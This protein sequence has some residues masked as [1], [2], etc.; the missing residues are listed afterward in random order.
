MSSTTH[1]VHRILELPVLD[2]ERE[3][4][5]SRAARA[6]DAAARE[7]LIVSGLRLVAMRARLLGFTGDAL[8]DAIQ[9]GTVGLIA[10]VD[11]FD[12]D[13]GVRLGTYAW[14][15]IGDAM[16]AAVP[17]VEPELPRD[18]AGT[19]TPAS[20]LDGIDVPEV[21]RLRYRIGE[22]PGPPRARH[23]VS[24]LLG[25][26]VHQVRVLETRAMHRLRRGLARVVHRAPGSGAD[27]L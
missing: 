14:W 6:G 11:R 4:E 27:P 1:Y 24:Q 10:A 20:A 8:G 25:I 12:P 18:L 21:L 19:T 3:V 22:L 16:R 17:V 5:L 26:S 23:E 7:Q 15:W 9:C 13:R 2:R